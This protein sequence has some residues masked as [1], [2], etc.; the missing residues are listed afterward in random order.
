[1]F[2][3]IYLERFVIMMRVIRYSS[4]YAKVFEQSIQNPVLYWEK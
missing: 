1:M 4:S 3:N 2:Y